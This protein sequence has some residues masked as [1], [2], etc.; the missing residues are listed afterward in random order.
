MPHIA[1]QWSEPVKPNTAIASIAV[2]GVSTGKLSCLHCGRSVATPDSFCCSGCEKVYHY[3]AAEGLTKYYSL[4]S[5]LEVAAPSQS[6][7]DDLADASPAAPPEADLFRWGGGRA[8]QYGFFV[9]ALSCA[10][11]LWLVERVLSPSH[12]DLRDVQDVRINLEEK[13][14]VVTIAADKAAPVGAILERLSRLG[15]RALP[16]KLSQSGEARTAAARQRLVDLGISGAV[17]ANV[18]LFATSVYFGD[19][20]G[21]TPGMARFFNLASLV[22]A[23]I[24]LATAGRSFFVTAWSAIRHR[25]MHIDL[26]IA[27]ALILAFSVSVVSL[28]TGRGGIYFDSVTG[29]IFLLLVG[30]HLNERLQIRARRLAQAVVSLIPAAGAQLRPGDEV[31]IKVGDLVPAD[32][33]VISGTSEVNEAALTGEPLPRVKKIGDPVFAGTHNVVGAIRVRVERSGDD[34]YV[35]RLSQLVD[36]AATR[37]SK[38]E[39]AAETWLSWFVAGIFVAAGLATV[40][41]FVKDSSRIVEVVCATLIVSCP[42]A[43]ALATPLTMATALRRAW[44]HGII[45]KSSEAFERAAGIDTIVLDKTGTLTTGNVRVVGVER[46]GGAAA[47]ESA[48]ILAV[49]ELSRHPVAKAVAGYLRSAAGREAKRRPVVE[50]ALETPGLGLRAT[51]RTESCTL[52]A[53]ERSFEVVIGSV[54]YLRSLLRGRPALDELETLVADAMHRSPQVVVIMVTFE[55]EVHLQV[56]SLEDRLH[57]EAPALISRWQEQGIDVYV[58]SGDCQEAV[59]RVAVACGLTSA[60]TRYGATPELKS[61]FVRGLTAKGRKVMMIGDGVNDAAAIAGADVG[62]AVSGGVDLA[63]SSADVFMGRTGLGPVAQLLSFARYNQISL[64]LILSLS[65]L[66]NVIAV[67]LAISG[68]LHPFVAA[69]I[70]PLASL[71]VI[72][73]GTLRRGESIWKSYTS[74]CPLPSPSPVAHS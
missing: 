5:S 64:R 22:L 1:A 18:M 8:V 17:F 3:L 67:A 2:R 16:P 12:E 24:S 46:S 20:W 52:A 72:L 50:S 15:Y 28:I 36:T 9:P 47:D 33:V 49:A 57:A 66:Y 19:I 11:C 63:L 6:T 55:A 45:V 23:A 27:A 59:A 26:P 38:F 56:L 73:I 53:K 51:G 14:V 69:S 32:G 39:T 34:C 10:A 7:Q 74:S 44:E 71:T 40:V 30:R 37:K 48:V 43:L 29:L 25:I 31:A 54:A 35:R 62:V 42:C 4:L 41:W 21:M 58:V 70:M 65:V 61:E 13:M 60:M 68:V